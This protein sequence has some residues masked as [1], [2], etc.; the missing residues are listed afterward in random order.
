[1]DRKLNVA[2]TR[3]RRQLFLV[4][5]A[6]ILRESPIYADLLDFYRQKEIYSIISDNTNQ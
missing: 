1:V 3:A 5:N 2:I 6:T 4:G